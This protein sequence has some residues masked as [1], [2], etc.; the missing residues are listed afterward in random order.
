MSLNWDS[1]NKPYIINAVLTFLY[2]KCTE[3]FGKSSKAKK[4]EFVAKY[5][6]VLFFSSSV[7]FVKEMFC[8]VLFFFPY[9]SG[10]RNSIEKSTEISLSIVM[11]SA[12]SRDGI[13]K[14]TN[15]GVHAGVHL[16]YLWRC[17]V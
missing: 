8:R 12:M 13:H 11:Q 3:N 1:V 4:L 5:V 15:V 7:F 6:R 17:I 9:N 10:L 14:Y 16:L 2:K